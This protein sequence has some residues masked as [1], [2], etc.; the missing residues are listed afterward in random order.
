M[1]RNRVYIPTLQEYM[2]KRK[3]DHLRL[4]DVQS[5]N[6]CDYYRCNFQVCIWGNGIKSLKTMKACPV[7]DR[8]IKIDSE[9]R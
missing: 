4:L 5:C 6:D 2:K 9:Q 1:S 7:T 8:L 3:K